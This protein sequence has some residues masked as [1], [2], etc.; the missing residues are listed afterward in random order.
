MSIYNKGD[1]IEGII[2]SIKNYGAF[3]SFENCYVG[4]LHISEIS[5]KFVSNIYNYFTIGD[6]IKVVIKEVDEETKHLSVSIKELPPELNQFKHI[7]SNRKIVNYIRDIDFTKLEKSL[8]NMVE[9]ELKREKEKTKD[10]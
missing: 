9:K 5:T 3:L 1:I 8:P 7:E 6:T 4:L 10:D 2:T